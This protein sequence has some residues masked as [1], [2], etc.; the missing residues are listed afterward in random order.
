LHY[1]NRQQQQEPLS[2]RKPKSVRPLVPNLNSGSN[3]NKLPPPTHCKPNLPFPILFNIIH[4]LAFTQLEKKN[5]MEDDPGASSRPSIGFP[6]GLA[7]LL[8]MLFCM[9][10]FFSCCLHWDKLRSLLH[11]SPD[12]NADIE[13]DIK[14]LPP[15]KVLF[16][17]SS[18]FSIFLD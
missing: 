10:A 18:S 6:L 7:L 2:V 4:V 12:E 15:L 16:F 8:L 3:L 17:S 9:S 1:A 11:S 5:I 13:A 14:P